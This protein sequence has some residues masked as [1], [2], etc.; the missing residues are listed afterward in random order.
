M[1]WCALP[2]PRDDYVVCMLTDDSSLHWASVL[3]QVST[4]E[5][6]NPT[7]SC[8]EWHHE[9][10]SFLSGSF[11]DSARHKV[12]FTSFRKRRTGARTIQGIWGR[13]SGHGCWTINLSQATHKTRLTHQ[14]LINICTTSTGSQEWHTSSRKTAIKYPR[15]SISLYTKS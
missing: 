13:S 9:P 4:V 7:L 12:V 15:E 10:L 1:R 3:T 11:R 2:T 14:H 6:D 8:N 5:F